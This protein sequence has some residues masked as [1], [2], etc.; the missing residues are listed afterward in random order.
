MILIY[1]NFKPYRRIIID[2]EL[3]I[4]LSDSEKRILIYSTIL[5]EERIIKIT[6]THCK[7]SHI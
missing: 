6:Y 1:A 5:Y 2:Y 4:K 7:W 3:I